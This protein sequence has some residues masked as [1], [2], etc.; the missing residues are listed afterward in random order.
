MTL[1]SVD[2]GKCDRD[3]RCIAACPTG[4]I[5]FAEKGA[6]PAMVGGGAAANSWPAMQEAL[7]LPPGHTPF[8]TLMAGYP[9]F[10]YH[11]LPRRKPPR[12][13]WK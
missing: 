13:T 2:P 7:Q 8:G 11:R 10:A 9:R 1:L 3:G 6:L 12:I 5:A 4:I